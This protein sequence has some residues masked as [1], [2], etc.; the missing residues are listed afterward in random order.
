MI[1]L[2][3]NRTKMS[4]VRLASPIVKVLINRE[5]KWNIIHAQPGGGNGG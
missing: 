2:D 1:H 5:T 3:F 4:T